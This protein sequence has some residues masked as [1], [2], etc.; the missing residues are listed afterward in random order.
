MRCV[1]KK[2]IN[3]AKALEMCMGH[4]YESRNGP[5]RR[6]RYS[7]ESI[8]EYL[9]RVKIEVPAP[10][11][12]VFKNLDGPCW[13][14]PKV[15]SGHRYPVLAYKGKRQGV[16]Q[17]SHELFLGPINGKYVLHKCDIP[18]CFN[19]KHLYLGTQLENMRD[20][21]ERHGYA[22]SNF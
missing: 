3:E 8:E 12:E 5:A 20:R 4:Y 10:S 18:A 21:Y 22:K 14:Y 1:V 9:N 2:C 15:H 17:W 19:P 11:G 7:I 6:I 13:I 16:H